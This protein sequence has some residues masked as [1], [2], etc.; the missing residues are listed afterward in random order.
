MCFLLFAVN[1]HPQY[2]FILAANRDEFFQ[3]PTQAAEF[4]QEFPQLF[5][6]R[7]LSQ[8]GTW[9]GVTKTGR[10]SALTNFRSPEN[11][12]EDRPSRGNLVSDFLQGSEAPKAYL[13]ELINRDQQYNGFNLIVGTLESLY[14]YSNRTHQIQ[15]L[16]KGIFGL[17]NHLLDTPWPK[18]QTGKL[19]FSALC[20]KPDGPSHD[21]LFELLSDQ[22][23]ATDTS[24]PDTGVG[25]DIE[26]KLS[27]IFIVGETYGTRSS[28]VVLVNKQGKVEF[29]E[30]T[31]NGNRTDYTETETTFL[32]EED[33]P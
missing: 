27:S 8:G 12:Q 4:W 3:R 2:P 14:Y 20:N 29:R 31:Y 18:V 21:Q 30:R 32:L 28:T 15:T 22:G 17:S 7:D 23:I 16:K 25:L 19:N 9:L 5:A 1:S 13:E 24:L 10:I 6:G 26:R 33:S 11:N